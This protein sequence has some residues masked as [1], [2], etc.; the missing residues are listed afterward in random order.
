MNKRKSGKG[1]CGVVGKIRF[2]NDLV[3]KKEG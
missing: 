1:N 3:N 2:I